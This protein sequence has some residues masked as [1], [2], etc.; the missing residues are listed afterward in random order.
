M[1][2]RKPEQGFTKQQHGRHSKCPEAARILPS[3]Q[4]YEPTPQDPFIR[5]D[6]HMSSAKPVPDDPRTALHTT[7]TQLAQALHN[8][9]EELQ[10]SLERIGQ[11]CYNAPSDECF[12]CTPIGKHVRHVL[13]HVRVLAS[14]SEF[15]SEDAV[16]NYDARVRGTEIETSLQAACSE[17]ESLRQGTLAIARLPLDAPV[18]IRTLPDREGSPLL[19]RSS[20]GRE[21][22]F[23]LSHT[24]HH[25]AMIRAMAMSRKTPLPDTLGYAPSTPIER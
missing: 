23:V 8:T 16:L 15:T 17:L 24:I 1:H 19:T 22:A 14:V 10:T 18:D 6:D 20:L 21:I 13:D 3:T 9:L 25:N 7:C 5:M 4:P 12:G 11:E 2:T